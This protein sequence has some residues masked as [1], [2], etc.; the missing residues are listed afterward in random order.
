M[1]LSYPTLSPR[2][3][4][5]FGDLA[6]LPSLFGP[7]GFSATEPSVFP[8]VDI[9]EDADAF[10]LRAELPGLG[11]EDVLVSVDDGVLRL[12]GEKAS[13]HT[14]EDANVHRRETF[15]GRFE[16]SFRLPDDVDAEAIDATF[17]AGVLT[18]RLPKSAP[19]TARA[20]EVKA[21]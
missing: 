11:H 6:S 18:V 16:R 10:A 20:I 4:W 8:A 13:N 21:C 12:S 3:R 7:A 14:A 17:K 19:Q 5:L 9:A 15:Y 1:T 2:R